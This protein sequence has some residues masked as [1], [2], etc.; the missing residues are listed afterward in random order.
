MLPQK[1]LDVNCRSSNNWSVLPYN[2]KE[3]DAMA[4]YNAN[5]SNLFHSS[6]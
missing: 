3:I 6:F 2:K 5:D 4:V 1:V